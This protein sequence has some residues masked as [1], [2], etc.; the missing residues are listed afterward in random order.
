MAFDFNS[1]IDNLVTAI[2]GGGTGWFFGRRGSNAA[3]AVT[4]GDAILKM[5]ESYKTFVED[6]NVK[7]SEMKEEIKVLHT[8][9]NA[10]RKELENCKKFSGL[11]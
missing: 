6:A 11:K 9:L 4:E 2:V 8:N 10:V 7:F 1:I 5:Q 3:A